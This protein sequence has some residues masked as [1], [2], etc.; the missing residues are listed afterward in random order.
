M[1][2]F[3]IY[4]PTLSGDSPKQKRQEIREYFLNTYTFYEKI[5]ELLKDESV[6]Y[7]KSEPTRHPMI[8]YYGHT[9]T[10]FIN[11][12]IL[13]KVIKE[14]I[15]PK[16]ESIFAVGV[17]E[18]SW[19]DVESKNYKWPKVSEVKEYRDSVKEVVL[20]L[21]E[22]LPLELPITQESE[23][24]ILLMGIEHERIHIETSLVL[25]RQMPL[26]FV[27]DVEGFEYAKDSKTT[28]S[29]EMLE[30]ALRDVTL[31]KD[32]SSEL[33]GWDNEY[34]VYEESVE[35]FQVSK[36]LVSNAEFM[37]FV[38]DNGYKNLEYWDDEGKE[39]LKRTQATHPTFW[40]KDGEEFKYRTL[41][42]LIEMPQNFPVDV[43]ALE[44]E[45]F[46]RY[47]SK[48][49]GVKY[50]LL[51]E[52]EYRALQEQCN[53]VD[54]PVFD[55]KD[56][57]Q[58]LNFMSATS[59][60]KYVSEE[61]YDVVGNVWQ[62]S[63]TPISGFEGFRVHKAY[64]DFSTPT[65]DNKHSLILGSSWASS[66]NLIMKHSRYAFRKHFYQNAGFRYVISHQKESS[67]ENS[68]EDDVVEMI[69]YHYESDR[70]Y[71]YITKAMKY[72]SST[73][74]ALDFGCSVGRSSFEL[75]RYFQNVEGVD[76]SARFIRV[77]V[78]LQESGSVEY[79]G[80]TVAL[81]S[82]GY[83]R[84]QQQVAFKQADSNNLKPIFEGYNLV[85][86]RV[87]TLDVFLESMRDRVES[88]TVFIVFDEVKTEGFELLEESKEFKICKK[89]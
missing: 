35:S 69:E 44:A 9:A 1:S 48:R 57:N 79:R 17:D 23:M 7:K 59:V 50:S 64:D 12:L 86:A 85:V 28:L 52:G 53:I 54:I 46:C 70:D 51:S 10:F 26:E 82:F 42:S 22:T 29:N 89:I 33:Y 77:G 13:M 27:K 30:V 37:E 84:V 4:P 31:G 65:F 76:T 16:F 75:A 71:S 6:F 58:N 5:F 2:K 34:G 60:D 73:Q 11:K 3:S 38:K 24:W 72:V 88:G 62:W 36:Y 55:E 61:F 20:E 41:S 81:E 87:D 18:M 66:G 49:D 8:F 43:N 32:E 68:Y 63:R 56:A 19:D 14:R 78:N 45:A 39:F 83:E 74:K 21:I 40:V 25:H 15:N 80:K 67:I 47:I